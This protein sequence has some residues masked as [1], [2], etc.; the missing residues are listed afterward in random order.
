MIFSRRRLAGSRPYGFR[1]LTRAIFLLVGLAALA[2]L[3]PR[4]IGGRTV[5]GAAVMIDGDSLRLAGRELRLEGVDAPELDQ[6]CDREGRSYGCG[7]EAKWIAEQKLTRGELSCRV[8]GDDRYGRGLALCAVAGEDLNGALVR[9][10]VAVSEG[11]Y[12]NEERLAREAGRGLW[13]GSFERP[14]EW[15]RR[16]PRPLER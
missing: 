8:S 16:H 5:T 12:R 11:L 9:E 10:G 1:D 4:F 13:A 3:L 6:V 14:A 2:L 7:R 15:R